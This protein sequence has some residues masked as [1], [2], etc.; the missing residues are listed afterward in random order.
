MKKLLYGTGMCAQA[1]I[2]TF[3][4]KQV[5]LIQP[6]SRDVKTDL[7]LGELSFKIC[8]P[9]VKGLS[10]R[11]HGVTPGRTINNKANIDFLKKLKLRTIPEV[12]NNSYFVPWNVPRPKMN[13]FIQKLPISFNDHRDIFLCS[14]VVGNLQAL[15]K[16]K[17]IPEIVDISDDLTIGIGSLQD[18][19]SNLMPSHFWGGTAFPILEI[20]NGIITFRPVFGEND[21]IDFAEKIIK[22]LL[23]VGF[24]TVQ[25]KVQQAVYLKFGI[26]PIFKKPRKWIALLQSN[27]QNFYKLETGDISLNINLIDNVKEKIMS[28]QL[29]TKSVLSNFVAGSPSY[30]NGIHLG[31][32]RSILDCVPDNISVLDTSLN[33]MPGTHPTIEVYCKVRQNLRK[34]LE[35]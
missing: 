21:T 11:Y 23:N 7:S 2:D 5:E 17:Y 15:Q 33:E 10:K 22:Q 20:P 26:Q 19:P 14:S 1:V 30:F 24:G 12:P 25:S 9:S 35:K 31:Y 4:R 18:L 28:S 16:H 29:Y 34:L 3:G 13:G 32:D 8:D 27:V 6:S